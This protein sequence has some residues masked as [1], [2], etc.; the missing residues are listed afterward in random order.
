MLVVNGEPLRSPPH[1]QLFFQVTAVLAD[2]QA[3]DVLLT[4]SADGLVRAINAGTHRALW[5]TMR[6]EQ[7]WWG[8]RECGSNR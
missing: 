3:P 4:A 2:P 5:R 6:S 8:L 1:A 7:V